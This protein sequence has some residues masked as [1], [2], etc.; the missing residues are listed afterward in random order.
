MAEKQMHYLLPN[1]QG[2]EALTCSKCSQT[3]SC[4][5]LSS[6][7]CSRPRTCGQTVSLS[8]RPLGCDLP[9]QAYMVQVPPGVP[10]GGVFHANVSGQIVAVQV[11]FGVVAGQTLQVQVPVSVTQHQ[12]YQQHQQ[13]PPHEPHQQHQQHKQ[14]KQKSFKSA[15]AI[16]EMAADV[17]KRGT[18]QGGPMV[19]ALWW[20]N[21]GL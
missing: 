21:M 11:P 15:A 13:H 14:H 10:P 17:K 5:A 20:L 4:K 6:C 18:H 19:S 2:S 3:N 8:S 7:L 1:N 9:M 12:Q 16:S